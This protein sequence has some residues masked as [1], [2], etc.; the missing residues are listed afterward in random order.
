MGFSRPDFVFIEEPYGHYEER[1]LNPDED[2]SS[3]DEP[4]MPWESAP[5]GA[6]SSR[7]HESA[8]LTGCVG[9]EP[10]IP[11]GPR[12]LGPDADSQDIEDRRVVDCPRCEKGTVV[13]RGSMRWQDL[14]Q[15]CSWCGGTGRVYATEDTA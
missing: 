4:S 14:H 8:P 2:A 1:I 5:A 12:P 13:T 15:R 7:V 10:A 11:G 9:P 6:P 3:R